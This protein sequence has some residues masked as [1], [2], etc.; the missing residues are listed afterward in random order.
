MNTKKYYLISIILYVLS[1]V[2]F[3][4]DGAIV[5][6]DTIAYVGFANDISKGVFPKSPLFQPG[7]GFF[8]FLIKFITGLDF[9]ISFRVLNFLYGLLIIVLINQF[10]LGKQKADKINILFIILISTCPFIAFYSNYLYADIG[11]VFYALISLH[12]LAKYI[13]INKHN[14]LILSS[15]FV[16]I[17]IFTKYNGMSV[18]IVGLIAILV[19]GVKNR[20]IF[21]LIKALVYYTIIP[22]TY[23]IFWK[24]YNGNLGGVE[25]DS[26]IK[27]VNIDCMIEY[28]KINIVSLYHFFLTLTFF[29]AHTHISHFFLI[30]P[31]FLFIIFLIFAFK[32]QS[33]SYIKIA[34]DNKVFLLYF[35]FLFTYMLSMVA[36]QSLNCITE[37]SIRV[38]I[39]PLIIFYTLVVHY[40]IYL[41]KETKTFLKK[42]ILILVFLYLVIFNVFYSIDFKSQNKFF[43]LSKSNNNYLKTINEVDKD[44]INHISNFATPAFVREHYLLGNNKRQF[45]IFPYQNF[46]EWD[47]KIQYS[48]NDYFNLLKEKTSNV[49]KNAFIVVELKLEF[50]SEYR[51]SI[52]KIGFESRE[53]NLFIFRQI[54]N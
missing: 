4:I 25:F 41:F 38:F 28:L 18:L 53:N 47:K 2:Y 27:I 24:Q 17:S 10:F 45:K 16:S 37:T 15:L 29:S 26:Y 46:Y 1:Y 32:K 50:I 51:D 48:N 6:N 11:F 12:F 42:V 35:L 14:T 54:A 7:V 22:L 39:T 33:K 49:E 34:Q 9:F 13:E 23:I 36:I 19:V 43:T 31:F 30:I 8:I 20:E 3:A 52:I 21:K 5:H 40:F 44:S